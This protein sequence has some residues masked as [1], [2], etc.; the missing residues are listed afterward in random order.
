MEVG[1]QDPTLDT[2]FYVGGWGATVTMLLKSFAETHKSIKESVTPEN[3]QSV[4]DW[5]MCWNSH[6]NSIT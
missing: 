4:S 5:L 6:G 1:A 3:L 2:T